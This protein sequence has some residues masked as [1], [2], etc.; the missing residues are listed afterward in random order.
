MLKNYI[1]ETGY[2]SL[3]LSKKIKNS[4]IVSTEMLR[5]K[6]NKIIKSKKN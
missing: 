4:E 2:F 3:K 1:I 6:I 5:S